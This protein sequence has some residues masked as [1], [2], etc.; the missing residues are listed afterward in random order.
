MPPSH[1]PFSSLPAPSLPYSG[2]A[3][4]AKLEPTNGNTA[5]GTV[6]FVQ[7]GEKVHVTANLTRPRAQ[8]RARLPRARK[9]RLQLR[10][11]H[12]R[13]RPFQSGRQA[14][15]PAGRAAPRAATCRSLK[16]DAAGKAKYDVRARRR[17]RRR[18]PAQRGRHAASSS[19][20]TR[21]T[22][23]RS[24]PATPA[25][26]SRAPSSRPLRSVPDP[27]GVWRR[28]RARFLPVTRS[29]ADTSHVHASAPL[30]YADNALEPVISAN[31]LGFHYGKHHK[32]YVDNLNN[33]VKG[34][35]SRGRDAREGIVDDTAGKADKAGDLQQ[36]RADLEPHVLLE[37]PASPAAAASRR[38]SSRR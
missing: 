8:R 36:R 7:R 30:P 4:V 26:A 5:A 2:P 19:T 34:T 16:A 6:E 10:R 31:T 20:R 21:T 28:P 35:G 11:R 17:H 33:L 1:P 23:R 3:A 9:R 13:R 14:A 27:R 38:A 12:E 25:R 37:Q 32:T 24:R 22:T 29:G 18:R 15:W